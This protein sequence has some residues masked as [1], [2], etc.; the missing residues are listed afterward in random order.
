[1][2]LLSG[3]T[4]ELDWMTDMYKRGEMWSGRELSFRS[5]PLMQSRRRVV[6]REMQDG[7]ETVC[8]SLNVPPERRSLAQALRPGAFFSPGSCIN[9]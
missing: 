7:S 8:D 5:A 4:L 6:S 3:R 1:M 9:S 2:V